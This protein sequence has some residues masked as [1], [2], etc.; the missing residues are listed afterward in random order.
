MDVGIKILG[1]DFGF[2]W[3][4]KTPQSKDLELVCKSPNLQFTPT[5]RTKGRNYTAIKNQKPIFINNIRNTPD[6]SYVGKYLKSYAIIPLVH[7]KAVHGS[8]VLCFKNLTNFNK[9]KK[10][11]GVLLG[12]SAAHAITIHRLV[13]EKVFLEQEKTKIEFMANATHELRTPLAIMRGN[14]ELA[15][16]EKKNLKAANY[17]LKASIVE[18]NILSDILKDLSLLTSGQAKNILDK[19]N[20]NLLELINQTVTRVRVLADQKNITI[21]VQGKGAIIV[22]GDESY[23]EEKLFLNIIKNAVTYGKEGGHIWVELKKNKNSAVIEIKDD[24]IGIP[25]DELPKI[26]GRFYRVE[27]AHAHNSQ[28]HSGLGLAIAKWVAQKHQGDITAK[29]V[30]GKGTT[31]TITL[32]FSK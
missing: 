26:F 28:N 19:K 31:F 20:I 25:K 5:A 22:L 12:N 3:Q 29:S 14:I 30:E 13:E 24:G 32:P 8:I 1:A 18:I 4:F 2:V 9:D 7:Q 17:A 11:L 21:Q 27:K 16:M 15:L 10:T 23:L 6:V